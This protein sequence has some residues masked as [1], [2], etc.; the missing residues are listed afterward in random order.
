LT[1]DII[2]IIVS[3]FI[4]PNVLVI[5]G[6][7]TVI[8]DHNVA[9]SIAV[10]KDGIK[11]KE[12]TFGYVGDAINTDS[13]YQGCGLKQLVTGPDGS[14]M[15]SPDHNSAKAGKIMDDLLEFLNSPA[16]YSIGNYDGIDVPVKTLM[17]Q[18]QALFF[19]AAV[20]DAASAVKTYD[21]GV[22]PCPK[23]DEAQEK[24]LTVPGFPY[25]MWAIARGTTKD[26]EDVCAVMEAMASEGY[27]KVVPIYFDTI[28][29]GRQDAVDDVKMLEIIRAGVVIDG[30]R[31][32]D[33][34]FNTDTWSIWRRCVLS[35][36]DYLAYY[37]GYENALLEQATSLN[38]LMRNMEKL[39]G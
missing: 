8:G 4:D 23:Y 30:G 33:S 34:A 28:V 29:T 10:D 36:R 20:M 12:D 37:E 17:N 26:Y 19:H 5:V 31:V 38:V 32:M 7:V 16:A 13:F 21:R 15:I 39:Y 35:N 25:H 2:Q 18:G 6:Q 27:R 9:D 1:A 14:V 24:Y 3:V 11:N 22:L